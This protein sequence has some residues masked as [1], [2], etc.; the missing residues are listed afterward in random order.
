MKAKILMAVASLLLL[1]LFAAPLWRITLEAPQYPDGITMYIWVN[2]ITG[3]SEYT[4]QNINILNHYVGMKYIEPDTIPELVY[5]PYIIGLMAFLG[6]LISFTNS[7]YYRLIWTMA[8]LTLGILGM[9]DFYLWE[10]DYGHNLSPL[11]PIKVPGMAYQPP[12]FG[13]EML[14]NFRASS[15]PH[16][17]GFFLFSSLI[18]GFASF[19]VAHKAMARKPKVAMALT[20]LLLLFGTACSDGPQA[21]NYGEESCHYCKMTIVDTRFGSELITTKGKIF[22]FDAVSCLVNHLQTL[23]EADVKSSWVTAYDA[24][25]VLLDV[26]SCNYLI[27]EGIRSPMGAHLSAFGSAESARS[28]QSIHGGDLF[29]WAEIQNH[30]SPPLSNE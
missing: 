26:N 6:C 1:A 3:D 24:P 20:A 28:F 19:W 25:E 27:S 14:L 13:S 22:K 23:D 15:Y 9:Y 16:W 10:Y 2:K 5:F 11:A 21:I 17:G 30:L 12:L 4:L 7:K 8:L 29:D 18:L